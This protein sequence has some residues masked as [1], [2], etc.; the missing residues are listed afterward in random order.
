M[1]RRVIAIIFLLALGALL[2]Q[3]G[4]WMLVGHDQNQEFVGPPRSDYTLTNFSVDA[5]DA[6]GQ[7]SFTIV[8]PRLARKED[9]GSIFVTAPDYDII[10]NSGNVW[11]GTSESAWINKDG[12]V[13]RLEGKVDMHR[14][15]TEKVDPV[16]LLTSDLTVTTTPKGKKGDAPQPKQKRMETAAL[17]T[18]IDPNHVAHGIGMKANL[19]G[20][21][22]LEFLSDVHWIVQPSSTA[23][24]TN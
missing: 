19:E 20:L 12:S 22:E 1:E 14:L 3:I 13:M 23:H 2:T 7:H 24:A 9:D 11:K 8:A 15:P 16:R 5:L 10:D 21:K 6:E 17:A 18:V 4:V